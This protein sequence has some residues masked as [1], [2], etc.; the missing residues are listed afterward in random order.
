M[1]EHPGR[2]GPLAD[3]GSGMRGRAFELCTHDP[4][5]HEVADGAAAMPALEAVL[6]LEQR[7]LGGRVVTLEPLEPGNPGV[8][9]ALLPAPLGAVEV[10]PELLRILLP[11]AE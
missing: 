10:R 7:R 4:S 3:D 6:L 11:E 2:E 8:A 9:V 5:E 1:A